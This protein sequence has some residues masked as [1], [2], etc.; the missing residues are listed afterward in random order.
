MLARTSGASISQAT[1]RAQRSFPTPLVLGLREKRRA[2][3]LRDRSRPS[4]ESLMLPV[5]TLFTMRS[6]AIQRD[7]ANA[8]FRMDSVGI[9]SRSGLRVM[10]QLVITKP[11]MMRPAT[12]KR[13]TRS[14]SLLRGAKL[15]AAFRCMIGKGRMFDAVDFHVL[16]YMSRY[17]C[18]LHAWT[19]LILAL[20][21]L[22]VST[23]RYVLGGFTKSK[24]RKISLPDYLAL[25]HRPRSIQSTLRYLRI[26]NHV[27]L[28]R[29]RCQRCS[30]LPHF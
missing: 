17:C 13:R 2:S 8:M 21:S 19:T 24:Y 28:A 18:N 4:V 10:R 27:C 5:T 12:R 7:S 1:T 29:H 15:R 6:C 30:T 3:A 14:K 26:I 25:T 22:H 23:K 9:C 20:C 16:H 11:A